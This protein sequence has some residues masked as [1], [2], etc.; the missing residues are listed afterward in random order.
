MTF[1]FELDLNRYE[2]TR[3]ISRSKIIYFKKVTVQTHRHTHSTNCSTWTTK[4]CL[5]TKYRQN[6]NED[7]EY[8][9]VAE[10]ATQGLRVDVGRDVHLTT[11]LATH[12]LVTAFN[13]E[14]KI[15]TD[16]AQWLG[17]GRTG[18]Q[19]CLRPSEVT[20]R[21]AFLF[22]FSLCIDVASNGFLGHV[23]PRLLTVYYP[24]HT[25]VWRGT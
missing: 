16:L 22:S 25:A 2:P 24:H 21:T 8:S 15:E 9:V 1:T 12:R 6:C 17:N 3:Q 11:E 5:R 14:T 19:C 18:L 23:T 13:S 10:R 7:L 4:T 20:T